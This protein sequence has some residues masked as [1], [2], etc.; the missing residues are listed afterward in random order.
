MKMLP[1]PAF[2]ARLSLA[3]L[4]SMQVDQ[5]SPEKTRTNE[6]EA[7]GQWMLAGTGVPVGASP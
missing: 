2:L 5:P 3:V 1:S 4:V 6:A 7:G